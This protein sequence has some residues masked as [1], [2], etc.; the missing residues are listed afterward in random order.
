MPY[1]DLRFHFSWFFIN[2]ILILLLIFLT[3]QRRVENVRHVH[4]SEQ[5]VTIAPPELDLDASYSEEDSVAE[6]DS[7]IEDDYEVDQAEAVVLEEVIP[8]RRPALPA[9]IRALKRKNTARKHR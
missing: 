9:W 7:V 5:V 3:D 1:I 2:L 4:F 8:A 6:D